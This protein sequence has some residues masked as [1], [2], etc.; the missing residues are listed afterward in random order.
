MKQ[1]LGMHRMNAA[2][3]AYVRRVATVPSGTTMEQITDPDFW[4]NYTRTSINVRDIIEVM[5]DDGAWFAELL[6]RDKGNV[7][8]RVAVLRH[9]QLDAVEEPKA[10]ADEDQLVVRHVPPL[11]WCV[12]RTRDNARLAEGLKMKADAMKR[13]AE[14]QKSAA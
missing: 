12:I 10:T 8:A 5:P 7:Q 11:D 2:E 6:V 4:G 3:S 14:L 13:L 9:I 1:K